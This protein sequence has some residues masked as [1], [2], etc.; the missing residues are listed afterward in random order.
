MIKNKYINFLQNQIF[1][2]KSTMELK[3]TVLLKSSQLKLK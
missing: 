2:R 3:Y 1:K